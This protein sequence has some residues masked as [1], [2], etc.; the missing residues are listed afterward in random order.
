MNIMIIHGPNLNLLGERET[1]IY[2]ITTLAEVDE[3]LR[4]RARELGAEL[5]IHQS[6]HEGA[7]VDAIQGARGRHQALIINPAAFTHYSIAV[8][9]ALA[10]LD[11]PVIEVHLSN[12]H[13]RETW[14]RRSVTA[15]VATGQISGFGP[16]SYLLALEA[17]VS[18]TTLGHPTPGHPIDQ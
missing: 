2:G 1:D 13:S 9:D 14:R 4:A 12:I 11:I 5:E 15:E 10:L 7:I 8:R 18:L 17:A 16:M 6:N 3:R